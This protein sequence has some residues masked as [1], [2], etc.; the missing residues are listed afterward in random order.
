MVLWFLI[1]EW[2]RGW[3]FHL[4]VTENWSRGTS[5]CTTWWPVCDTWRHYSI[6][7][8]T[9]PDKKVTWYRCTTW[10]I[11]KPRG[12]TVFTTIDAKKNH[13]CCRLLG[14]AQKLDFPSCGCVVTWPKGIRCL[15]NSNVAF[16][17]GFHEGF[18]FPRLFKIIYCQTWFHTNWTET[19]H[20]E[21]SELLC[22]HSLLEQT[23]FQ[24]KI[25]HPL[26]VNISMQL[27]DMS[28]C[29]EFQ[30]TVELPRNSP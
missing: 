24:A 12:L 8:A 4:W 22:M 9:L 7:P 2:L 20:E 21:P 26:R 28:A 15:L 30:S 11:W 27:Q 25:W 1:D 3:V 23:E 5:S 29:N 18:F 6:R 16:R 17:M 14:R 19:T 13:W 10:C